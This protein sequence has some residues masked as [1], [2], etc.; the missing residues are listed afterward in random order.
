MFS[1]LQ[2]DSSSPYSTTEFFVYSFISSPTSA[3]TRSPPSLHQIKS[4]S[5]VIGPFTGSLI[6]ISMFCFQRIR[7]MVKACL[8][9]A[10][11]DKHASIALPAIGTG[12]LCV[13]SDLV[14][15]LM[16]DE[17]QQFSSKHPNPNLRD[18][19]FI[20]FPPD[21][22][23]VSVSRP[24]PPPKKRLTRAMQASNVLQ[25]SMPH[26]IH[27]CGTE[28]EFTQHGHREKLLQFN[29]KDA[30]GRNSA[31]GREVSFI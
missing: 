31:R 13:P 30:Y 2:D 4:G 16:Y 17:A 7:A 25:C 6:H 3:R 9:R 28:L 10:N 14:A 20:V 12:N 26:R 29:I 24:P 5:L 21:H 8:K 11:K 27:D 1:S 19:R 18:I 22:Q 15:K 23:T